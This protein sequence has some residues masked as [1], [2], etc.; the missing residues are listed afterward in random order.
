MLKSSI[1]I[2]KGTNECLRYLPSC[3]SFHLVPV[4]ITVLSAV[5]S[6]YS[7]VFCAF[8]VNGLA[9]ITSQGPSRKDSTA[10]FN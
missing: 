8:C 10:P 3:G 5:F 7:F 2:F 4:L 1:K 9:V 6:F